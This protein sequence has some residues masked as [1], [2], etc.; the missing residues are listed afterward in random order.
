M[1]V[2]SYPNKDSS[3]LL[4]RLTAFEN[5]AVCFEIFHLCDQYLLRFPFQKLP[6]NLYSEPTLSRARYA[7]WKPSLR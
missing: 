6:G 2:Q 5:H 4:P 7:T 1:D 3:I